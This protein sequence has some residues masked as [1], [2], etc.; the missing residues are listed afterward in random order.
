[1]IGVAT[2]HQTL[3]LDINGN[4]TDVGNKA[5]PGVKTETRWF[6]YRID[7]VPKWEAIDW[8]KWENQVKQVGDFHDNSIALWYVYQGNLAAA[9]KNPH[10]ALPDR[11]LRVPHRRD[12]RRAGG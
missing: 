7:S 8:T 3:T 9:G 4:P 11:A 5:D 6:G 2:F 10:F 1:V 12:A